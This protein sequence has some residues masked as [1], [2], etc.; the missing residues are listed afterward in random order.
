VGSASL[1][2]A[3]SFVLV[4]LPFTVMACRF[5]LKALWSSVNR[6]VIVT[7]LAAPWHG[8][9]MVSSKS[10][11]SM[12]SVIME[13]DV[14]VRAEKTAKRGEDAFGCNAAGSRCSVKTRRCLRVL[15][16]RVH[17]AGLFA[18]DRPSKFSRVPAIRKYVRAAGS[19]G[20]GHRRPR[21]S[22]AF[23][24]AAV[25]VGVILS[26]FNAH[27][28]SLII[29]LYFSPRRNSIMLM[30]ALAVFT[31]VAVMGLMM[32]MDVWRGRRVGM[33]YSMTHAAAA[34]LGS[35]LV[36]AVALDGDTRL[37]A[38]IGMAV[39][40][41][42]LGVAMGFA[43]KKGKSAPKLVLMAHA[44]L[45]VACYGLLGFFALNPDATLM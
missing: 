41:I 35:A 43:V 4:D 20:L 34:L 44:A 19:A 30:G 3:K 6:W 15:P 24:T 26:L 13:A 28:F 18:Q 39:V 25:G 42:L 14:T 37:Y 17:T 32:I 8:P 21:S 16:L 2:T 40:I 36:I 33:A 11:T 22:H 10:T 29:F 1:R 38:N 7:G 5:L 23:V 27:S 12:P 31:L 45:A 9:V